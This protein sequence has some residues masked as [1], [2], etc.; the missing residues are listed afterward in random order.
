M[1]SFTPDNSRRPS[2][3]E[4]TDSSTGESSACALQARPRHELEL[5]RADRRSVGGHHP[6]GNGGPVAPAPREPRRLVGDVPVSPLHQ[7]EQAE[8]ELASLLGEVV[9]EALRALAVSHAVENALV[10]ESA[11]A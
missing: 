5:V 9:F 1:L 2:G 8:T 11:Q 4:A 3:H 7:R 10:D 6:N